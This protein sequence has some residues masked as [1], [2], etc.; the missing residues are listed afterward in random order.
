MSPGEQEPPPA[1]L[2]VARFSGERPAGRAYS[3]LQDSIFRSPGCELSVFRLILDRQW[4]VTVL[5]E[6][7]AEA[8][9][10]RIRQV[11]SRGSPASLPAEIVEE[12]Q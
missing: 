2:Q 5:G 9:D 4:H 12:L 8:L 3:Q 11:L 7:P 1:Y 6:P 10:R